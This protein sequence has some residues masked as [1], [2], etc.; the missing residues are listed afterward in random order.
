MLKFPVCI[1]GEFSV[2]SCFVKFL[3][4]G[5]LVLV[6]S[7]ADAKFA[8]VELCHLVT[9]PVLPLRVNIVEFV[10]EQIVADP[11]IIPPTLVGITVQQNCIPLNPQINLR[12]Y[13]DW[14]HNMD[15][16]HLKLP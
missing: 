15:V 8:L 13:L 2:P 7:I 5:A 10:P 4:E 11:A 3:K 16:P 12:D 6:I 14:K 9:V 1:N